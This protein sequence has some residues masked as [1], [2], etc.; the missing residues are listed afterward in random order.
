MTLCPHTWHW[1]YWLRECQHCVT[2]RRK[3]Q[4]GAHQPIGK[5]CIHCGAVRHD[6]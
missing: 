2:V 1:L 4:G 3:L 5:C 6:V